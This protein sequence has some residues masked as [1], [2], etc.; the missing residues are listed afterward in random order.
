MFPKLTSVRNSIVKI[1]GKSI[2]IKPWTNRNVL[3]YENAKDDVQTAINNNLEFVNIFEKKK[4]F[5]DAV[6]EHLVK[7]NIEYD[8]I[9]TTFEKEVLFIEMYKISR[10]TII[11]L[12]YSCPKCKGKS[13]N[14]FDI[15]KSVKYSDVKLGDINTN[16]V[17]FTLK[18][19]SFDESNYPDI[20]DQDKLI[21]FYCSFV[22][23]FTFKKE[24]FIV[25]DLTEFVNWVLEELSETDYNEFLELI[26]TR[27]P[28]MEMKAP[29]KC[30]FCGNTEEFTCIQLPDF[31][32]VTL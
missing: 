3:Y 8:G 17:C 11:T 12:S 21:Y 32:L 30:D 25:T 13:A 4:L 1:S 26:V 27:L 5:M 10:G 16:N 2:N 18:S 23:E 24:K 14:N 20:A 7:P 6:F 9:L 15:T 31:S 28:S 29:M 19:S 22:K